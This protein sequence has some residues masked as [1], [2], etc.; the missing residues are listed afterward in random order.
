MASKFGIQFDRSATFQLPTTIKLNDS[1]HPISLPV[2]NG[3][4]VAFIELLLDDCYGCLEL[5]RRGLQI[6]TILDIGANVGLFGIAARSVFPDAII[7]SYE[8]NQELEQYLT[9][10]A[11]T[12]RFDYFIEAVGLENGMISLDINEDSV[13]TRSKKDSTGNVLQTAFSEAIDRLGGKIDLLKMDCEGAEWEIFKD[14]KSWGNIK[15]LA[16]EY[17]LFEPNHTLG[18]VKKTITGLGFTITSLTQADKF[19]LVTATRTG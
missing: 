14:K 3:V 6:K 5:K 16:M 13:Q 4:K 19:G 9:I 2:E 7:H 18:A 10:Q 8:P 15:N 11:K 1:I 12:A 17:H